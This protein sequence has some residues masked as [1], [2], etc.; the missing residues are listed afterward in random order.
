[1]ALG[2]IIIYDK[3]LQSHLEGMKDRE[4]GQEGN[5]RQLFYQEEMP[6]KTIPIG[7]SKE[8]GVHRKPERQF[9][10]TR[11]ERSHVVISYGKLSGLVIVVDRYG[12]L[13]L[14]AFTKT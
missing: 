13:R 8:E 1:M 7:K 12:L 5:E 11:P 4:T 14:H 10:E 9:P 2:F 6:Q 3:A